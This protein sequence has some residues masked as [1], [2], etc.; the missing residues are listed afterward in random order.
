MPLTPK[1]MQDDIENHALESWCAASARLLPSDECKNYKII[2]VVEIVTGDHRGTIHMAYAEPI[3]SPE[4][5]A[6]SH[7][8]DMDDDCPSGE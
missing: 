7:G 3:E 1:Q 2:G 6:E 4:D 8:I 5:E